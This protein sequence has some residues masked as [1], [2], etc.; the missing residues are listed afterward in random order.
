M[1]D[2][3]II[4]THEKNTL[5]EVRVALDEFHGVDLVDIR[6]FADFT[7]THA[8]KRATKKG[9]SLKV[10]KLPKLILALEKAR[11]EAEQRGLLTAERVL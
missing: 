9:I 3:L 5:E 11:A 4:A 10:G 1:T 7:G 2:S 6:V 8:E